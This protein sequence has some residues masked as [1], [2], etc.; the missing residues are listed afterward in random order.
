MTT[1]NRFL[2]FDWGYV[3]GFGPNKNEMK[4]HPSERINI[5]EQSL[6][7]LPSISK[8]SNLLNTSNPIENQD[9]KTFYSI[10]SLHDSLQ[11]IFSF[12]KNMFSSKMKKVHFDLVEST[13][14]G[15]EV[16]P[17]FKTKEEEDQKGVCNT[18]LFLDS[19]VLIVQREEAYKG[20][21]SWEN[22]SQ[23]HLIE[24]VVVTVERQST[25]VGERASHG[26]DPNYSLESTETATM[27]EQTIYQEEQKK[28]Q[29]KDQKKKK[30]DSRKSSSS[31]VD[32]DLVIPPLTPSFDTD[33]FQIEYILRCKFHYG[34]T[35]VG[36][37]TSDIEIPICLVSQVIGDQ[38]QPILLNLEDIEE[39]EET[40]E[41]EGQRQPISLNLEEI[42]EIEEIKEIQKIQKIQKIQELEGQGQNE[43]VV[44]EM[45]EAEEEALPL[46]PEQEYSEAVTFV[47]H[48]RS[49]HNLLKTKKTK[50]KN[51]NDNEELQLV[52]E[53]LVDLWALRTFVTVGGSWRSYERKKASQRRSERHKRKNSHSKRKKVKKERRTDQQSRSNLMSCSEEVENIVTR[54]P[55]DVLNKWKNMDDTNRMDAQR[56][57]VRYAN[58]LM[59]RMKRLM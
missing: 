57:Y 39:I 4:Y 24:Q 48:C 51:T 7:V 28:D 23:H 11:N 32:F 44:E 56:E 1:L 2:I 58:E 30:N 55:L 53:L 3:F 45:F 40:E 21:V 16:R 6:Y 10:A 29:K 22:K 17:S 36:S 34:G 14:D 35:Y 5:A 41:L 27:Y 49:T 31:V 43:E 18:T 12:T 38:R 47:A 59:E 33:L 15:D 42:E 50:N 52:T 26:A 20:V 37:M 54:L 25:L 19:N 13:G 9:T 46:T 8:R